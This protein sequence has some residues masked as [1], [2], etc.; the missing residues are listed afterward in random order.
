QLDELTGAK[1]R[2]E[3]GH[4]L[5]PSEPGI[6]IDW[7]SSFS[8]AAERC[9]EVYGFPELGA[10]AVARRVAEVWMRPTRSAP[11][12]GVTGGSTSLSRPATPAAPCARSE[13]PEA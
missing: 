11:Q 4:A 3:D 7:T 6:G 2:I 10:V 12:E 9:F 13:S 5:A 1:M 8:V